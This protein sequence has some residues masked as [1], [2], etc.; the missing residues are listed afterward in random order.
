MSKPTP[1]SPRYGVVLP[2]TMR[3]EL[4]EAIQAYMVRIGEVNRSATM[5]QLMRLGLEAEGI[6]LSKPRR[7][8][9]AA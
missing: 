7:R 8:K 6:E 3:P 1:K 5:R 2:V 4:V 9:V